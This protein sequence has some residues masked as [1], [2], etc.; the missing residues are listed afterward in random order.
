M[1]GST[2]IADL[3]ENITMSMPH[4]APPTQGPM[5]MPGGFD[6]TYQ[7]MNPHPNPFGQGPPNQNALPPPQFTKETNSRSGGS[8]SGGAPTYNPMEFAGSFNNNN[9]PALADPS[10][11]L[12]QGM[13]QYPLPQRDIPINPTGYVQDEAVKPNY[14][15]TPHNKNGDF[16]GQQESRLKHTPYYGKQNGTG[17]KRRPLFAEGWVWD[18]VLAEL[19][20]PII[21]AILFLLFQSASI[22]LSIAKYFAFLNVTDPDSLT[23]NYT[24]TMVKSG[25]FGLAYFGFARIMEYV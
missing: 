2:R 4:Q 5:S 7:P 10:S 24:G 11:I 12:K 3:P 6:S 23:L 8:G 17:G 18:D 25:L 21:V 13:P 14:I 16:V 15:P 19:Q 1:E 22:N 20:Q 9:N